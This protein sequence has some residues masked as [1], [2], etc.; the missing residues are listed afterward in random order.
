M[1]M[2]GVLIAIPGTKLFRQMIAAG[3]ITGDTEG[4]SYDTNIAPVM[5][6]KE[7]LAGYRALVQKLYDPEIFFAR[8][9]RELDEWKQT[10][11]RATGFREYRAALRSVWHQ[12]VWKAPYKLQYWKFLRR[13]HGTGKL[14]RAIAIAIYYHH[15]YIYT[16]EVILP[17]L[18]A[19]LDTV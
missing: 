2:V 1:A 5:G 15:L 7:L 13:F 8:A 18:K 6:R 19:E 11:V 16:R 14:P 4:D 12:G 9:A 17:R 3:R 10:R